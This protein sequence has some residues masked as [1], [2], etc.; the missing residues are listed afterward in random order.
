MRNEFIRLFSSKVEASKSQQPI[1]FLTGDLGYS[2]LEPLRDILGNHFINVG[3]AEANMISI[4]AGLAMQG[5]K[6]F[7]YSIAPF[8]TFRCLEQIRNDVCYHKL[9]VTVIGIGVGY[10]YGALGPTHHTTEDLSAMWGLPHMEVYSPADL[11]ELRFCFEASL[12]NMGPK[13]FRLGKGGEG[14]F[15]PSDKIANAYELKQ[16]QKM[17][18]VSTGLILSEILK[19]HDENHFKDIQ[20]ISVPHL[21]PFPEQELLALISSRRI[22]VVEELSPYGGFSGQVSKALMLSILREK[23]QKYDVLSARDA[24][25]S[26]PGSLHY[27]RK[28]TGLSSEHI[29]SR[30]A[31]LL[32][33]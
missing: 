23:I 12:K 25:A 9:D 8:A 26:S 4:A 31:A 7:C 20:V 1:Y 33:D 2:V 29:A 10:G 27:Q 14:D 6:V 18:V 32:E 11:S 17:T 28:Q 5:A 24:F 13:Y 22:L 21:K 15:C 3:V 19:A 30:F 16:G